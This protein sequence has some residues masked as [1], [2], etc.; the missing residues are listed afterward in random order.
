MHVCMYVLC[1]L[2]GT[3]CAC[4]HA[5][6]PVCRGEVKP[7]RFL[8][9]PSPP[10]LLWAGSGSLLLPGGLLGGPVLLGHELREKVSL[11][12]QNTT[13]LSKPLQRGL[14]ITPRCPGQQPRRHHAGVKMEREDDWRNQAPA[15]CTGL[16]GMMP[17]SL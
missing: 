17:M 12:Q 14:P 6:M 4:V 8:L 5:G 13:S 7:S 9:F 10:P 11:Q 16:D 3:A 1:A 15:L 2:L